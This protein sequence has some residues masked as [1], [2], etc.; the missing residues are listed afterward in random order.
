MT[1]TKLYIRFIVNAKRLNSACNT[2]I[3]C[4]LTYIKNRKDFSPGITVNPDPS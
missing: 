1:T 3:K 2:T 4:R